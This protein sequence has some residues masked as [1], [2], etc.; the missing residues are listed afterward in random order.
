MKKNPLSMNRTDCRT[1]WGDPSGVLPRTDK[2]SPVIVFTLDTNSAMGA[3]NVTVH[4]VKY[5]TYK[6]TVLS[7]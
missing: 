4:A 2:L 1:I 6:R 7:Q 5:Y 3:E